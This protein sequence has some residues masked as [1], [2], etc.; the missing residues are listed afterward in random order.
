MQLYGSDTSPYVR[1]LRIW[2]AQHTLDVPYQHIDI[3]SP[4]G[5]KLLLQHTPVAKIP[6]LVDGQQSI[7]DSTVIFE[8]LSQA[9]QL[10]P[11]HWDERNQL[12]TINAANDSGVELL[13]CQRSGFDTTQDTLFFN[14]QHQRISQCLGVLEELLSSGKIKHAYVLTSLFCLLDWLAFRQLTDFSVYSQLHAFWQQ[15]SREQ[16]AQQTDPRKAE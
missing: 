16:L 2:C 1:R 14:L 10:K 4:A 6:V 13:L 3:F 9:H 15:Y 5:R 7:Y 11:L 12:T 8:Y